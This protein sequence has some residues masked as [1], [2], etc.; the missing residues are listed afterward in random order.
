MVTKGHLIHDDVKQYA[1]L[2]TGVMTDQPVVIAN[3]ASVTDLTITNSSINQTS[4][5]NNFIINA[6]ANDLILQSSAGDVRL[7]TNGTTR[8]R[9]KQAGHLLAEADNTY[10]I[11]ASGANRPRT[12]YAASSVVASASTPVTIG[13]ASSG[14]FISGAISGALSFGTGGSTRWNI[15][16]GP[17]SWLPQA[18]NAVDVGSGVRQVRTVYAGTSFIGPGAV[19]VGGTTGQVLTKS[20]A[21]D[22][23]VGWVTP[24]GGA[25]SWPLLAPNGAGS[26][27]SYSF[28]ADATTGVYRLGSGALGLTA[29]GSSVVVITTNS[30]NSVA[31]S[32][33]GFSAAFPSPTVLS[34]DAGASGFPTTANNSPTILN[35]SGKTGGSGS[36]YT[37]T[38]LYGIRLGSLTAGSNNTITNLY[39]INVANQGGSGVANAYG[40]Y[41]AAQSGASTTNLGLYNGGSEQVVGNVGIGVA[42]VTYSGLIFQPTMSGANQFALYAPLTFSTTGTGNNFVFYT[43]P[44][45]AASTRTVA[46]GASFYADAPTVGAGVTVTSMFGYYAANQG[47]SGV[48]NA[49]GVYIAAQSGASSTNIGLRNEGTT[50]LTGRVGINNDPWSDNTRYVAI[51]GVVSIFNGYMSLDNGMGVGP[52]SATMLNVGGNLTGA[53]TQNGM[54]FRVNGDATCTAQLVGVATQIGTQNGSYTIPAATGFY[55]DGPILG[56]GT[57]ITTVRGI[58]IV[59]Q[60]GAGRSNAYGLYLQATAGASGDNYSL[61]N[62]G[63]SFLGQRVSIGSVNEYI[64]NPVNA[65]ANLSIESSDGYVMVSSKTGSHLMANAYWDG[66]NWNR[67]DVA[68]GGMGVIAGGN[69]V[70]F[71]S[72]AS[73][74]NPIGWGA[75]ASV[76]SNGDIR[77]NTG[78]IATGTQY[79][80]GWPIAGDLNVRRGSSNSGYVFLGDSQ[81]YVGF[82]GTQYVILGPASLGIG[83][84]NGGMIDVS[85]G[86]AGTGASLPVSGT[87]QL[88][89]GQQFT[90][91]FMVTDTIAVGGV[92]VYLTGGGT[93]FLLGQTAAGAYYSAIKDTAGHINVY[94]DAAAAYAV[95]VQNLLGQALKIQSFAIKTRSAQ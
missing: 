62:L 1:D 26:A 17:G 71:Y 11:G 45:F 40:V 31:I 18:D 83:D 41:I 34:M 77:S 9:T 70:S 68:S 2:L 93:I 95:T 61:Y 92:A 72:V 75:V 58:N 33:G 36:A 25:L 20:S 6:G 52:S 79:S 87:I 59:N 82:D 22:Y 54:Y 48:T 5:I 81:H 64:R 42:P 85:R 78:G 46:S 30:A 49:Y 21:T 76:G 27:P 16:F 47:K 89:G 13:T 15:D 35:L 51:S 50:R 60:G 28:S 24:S 53:P 63:T 3:T 66:T 90:G 91:M 69:T 7:A 65:P 12:I 84:G 55:I 8:W 38:N 67:F 86:F 73:G 39:G 23:A 14:A 80:A 57:S 19:P 10:D 94:L 88:F 56:T 44:T 4:F 37:T 74:S 32:S 29:Q 43:L